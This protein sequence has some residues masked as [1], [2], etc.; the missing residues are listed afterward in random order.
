[1]LLYKPFSMMY[2]VR[3]LFYLPIVKK[4]KIICFAL[5]HFLKAHVY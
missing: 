2:H 4:F 3:P 5:L 1:M